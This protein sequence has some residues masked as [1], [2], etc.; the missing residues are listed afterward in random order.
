MAA[1]AGPV[2]VPLA[3]GSDFK[4]RAFNPYTGQDLGDSVP[5]GIRMVSRL[6]ALHDDLFGG[7]TGRRV[8]GLG[9]VLVLVLALTGIIVWWPGVAYWRR[10]LTIDTRASSP[11]SGDRRHPHACSLPD[12]SAA[13]RASPS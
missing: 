3:R 6:L 7:P 4:D 10:A 1:P 8:N 2:S 12:H 13:I 9:A 5:P 11:V